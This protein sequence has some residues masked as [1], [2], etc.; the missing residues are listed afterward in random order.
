LTPLL[1]D[2]V[3]GAILEEACVRR[4]GQAQARSGRTM[5]L[6]ALPFGRSRSRCKV[7][8]ATEPPWPEAGVSAEPGDGRFSNPIPAVKAANGSR[9]RPLSGVKPTKN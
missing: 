8:R 2:W 7:G 5:I 3:A 9:K 6:A 1:S 4:A